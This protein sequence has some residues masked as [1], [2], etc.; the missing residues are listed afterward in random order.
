MLCILLALLESVIATTNPKTHEEDFK[1][2]VADCV[3]DGRR[4]M[5]SEEC[6][7]EAKKSIY[8]DCMK[9]CRK[10]GR[11][12]YC[13]TTHCYM[14]RPEPK[15][16]PAQ[17]ISNTTNV[18]NGWYTN[19]QKAAAEEA[20][21][22]EDAANEA[23]KAKAKEAKAQKAEQELLIAERKKR[24]AE[25]K[26]AVEKAKQELLIAERKKRLAEEKTAAEK[27]KQELLIA[28]RRKRLAEEKT[29]AERAK[30]KRLA[31]EKTAAEE[32]EQE[33]LAAEQKKWLAEEANQKR[34]DAESL[35][36]TTTKL[37]S[38]MMYLR[39]LI[40]LVGS[41]SSYMI[42]FG[43]IFIIS[44][45]KHFFLRQRKFLPNNCTVYVDLPHNITPQFFNAEV[46]KRVGNAVDTPEQWNVQ[47]QMVEFNLSCMK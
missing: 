29:A 11:E 17:H 6:K 47:A 28:E 4:N 46:E 22:E 26:T 3:T 40:T 25:E 14:W 24:L 15:F 10:V 36:P 41:T 16:E 27:A 2:M 42:T 12:E 8:A 45:T 33:L 5:K 13:K 21:A 31:E 9:K 34:R 35:Q 19:P 37:S 39:G 20:K 44:T 1:S 7:V 43:A 38:L 30:Q 23:E 18:T 32:A